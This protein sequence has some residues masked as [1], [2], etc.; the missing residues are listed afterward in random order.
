MSEIR[1][2]RLYAV[3]WLL[4]FLMLCVVYLSGLDSLSMASNGD[5][6]VYARIARLTADSGQWL[7]LVSDL[8]QMR[9]TKPPL[10]FWQ[11]LVAGDWGRHWELA[12]LR[13]PAVVYSLLIAALLA[14]TTWLTARR[15]DLALVAACVYLAFFSSF[16][17]GRPYLT[18]AAETFWLTLPLWAL[19][20][21]RTTLPGWLPFAG[22]GLLWG[23]GLLYKSFALVLPAAAGLWCAALALHHDG[24][25]KQA[26]AITAR[27][28]LSA[29]IGLGVF[30]LWFALDPDPGAVWREFVVGENAGKLVT[31]SLPWE[32]KAKAVLVQALAWLENAGSLAPVIVGVMLSGLRG[33]V[34]TARG[35]IAGAAKV[36]SAGAARF[37]TA[38]ATRSGSPGAAKTGIA[39]ALQHRLTDA[40]RG[41]PPVDR[42][43]VALAAW[44]LVWLIVFCLPS[45]RSARYVIPAMPALAMLVALHW[46]RLHRAWFVASALLCLPVL[47]LLGRI[48]Q[49]LHT[50]DL[51]TPAQSALA[52]AALL[53]GLCA[54]S[55]SLLRPAWSRAGALASTAAVYAL[56]NCTLAPL[57]GP[58]GQFSVGPA[59]QFSLS[60]E[61]RLSPGAAGPSEVPFAARPNPLP[62]QARVAVPS[63]FNAQHERYQ[64]LLP[65]AATLRLQP[66]RPEA[67]SEATPG[68]PTDQP[69]TD[70]LRA[71]SRQLAQLL[72]EHDAVV[73]QQGGDQAQP[74]CALPKPA[75]SGGSAGPDGPGAPAG[76]RI[77]AQ[78]WDIRT[79]HQPG[80]IRLDNLAYP[81]QWLLR[82][83]WLLVKAAEP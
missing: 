27:V 51:A 82:R 49:T 2:S 59:G 16:R 79:R 62:A 17:Y 41:L 48:A 22:F 70:P 60:P 19:L 8:D 77:A 54:V 66:Y 55:A 73:W 12:R 63:T 7:P 56:L 46:H 68:T 23:I 21:R 65:N 64:F 40:V 11:A 74:P 18:S 32:A 47:L 39:G 44:A 9:N 58:G 57:S 78:R 81:A 69:L 61:S 30:A 26:M 34:S 37:G 33:I 1:L 10:L 43:T 38:G 15:H 52:L 53:A 6:M 42:Q 5:E 71:G 31:S 83:E 29:L 14:W 24:S 25:L 28:A 67:R 50:Q 4:L 3:R 80:E 36:D 20:W 76:C 35:A 75:G 45:Q 72:H 13:L